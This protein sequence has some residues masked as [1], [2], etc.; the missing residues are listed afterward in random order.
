MAKI[1][2]LL[3]SIAYGFFIIVYVQRDFFLGSGDIDSYV[4]YFDEFETWIDFSNAYADQTYFSFTPD[5]PIKGEGVFRL[6]VLLLRGLLNQSTLTILGYLA[7]I[8]S[9]ILFCIYAIN[10]RSRK[11]L[12]YILPL[13]L[14]VFF[15]PRI[16]NL[17]ASGIR[18]GIAFTILMVAIIYLK[19]AKKYILFA[20]SS[21]FHLS[22]VPIISLYF[23]FY[24]LDNKRIKSSF[25]ASLFILLLCS[26]LAAIA[27]KE[28]HF[29]IGVSQS[30]YYMSLVFVVGLF[31]IF[32]NKNGIKNLYGFM[33]A[34][35]ILIIFFG[36]TMDFSF[37]RYIGNAIILY[38][39]FLI[40]EGEVR[41]IQVFTISY[42]PF[43]IL[44][45]Y[46]SI[47]NYW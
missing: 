18:S 1:L 24:M 29:S 33:S 17:F 7:F 13:F 21:L 4:F 47:A 40:K 43:F 20:L 25:I 31:I 37:I 30:I 16:M 39:F 28:F 22:M 6:S 38:L 15:T 35:L 14:M 32:T 42:V 27:G 3:F 5:S 12:F 9:S 11:Y 45:L 36:Y 26:F 23:I 41:T 2:G 34:G 44:T 19:G 10:I 8:M 46:Y